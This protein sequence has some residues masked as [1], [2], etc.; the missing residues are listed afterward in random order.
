MGGWSEEKLLD[1]AVTKVAK[2]PKI[3]SFK[4]KTIADCKFLF[5]LIASIE[6]RIINWD[7]VTAGYKYLKNIKKSIKKFRSNTRR[8]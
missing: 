4:D 2:E 5:N 8:S 7:L 6:P 1:W 3:N